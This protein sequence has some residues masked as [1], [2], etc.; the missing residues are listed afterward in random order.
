MSLFCEFVGSIG[1]IQGSLRMP[2]CRLVIALFIMLGSGAM[3]L[4]SKLVVLGNLLMQIVH[5]TSLHRKALHRAIY[6]ILNWA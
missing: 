5:D 4:S 3:G 2:V 1:V 6:R